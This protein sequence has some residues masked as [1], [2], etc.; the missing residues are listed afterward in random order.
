MQRRV[1]PHGLDPQLSKRALQSSR[2]IER[3]LTL[4]RLE[5]L[6]HGLPAYADGRTVAGTVEDGRRHRQGLSGVAA[7]LGQV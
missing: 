2:S 6:A 5:F 4:E 3:K 1:F 7:A